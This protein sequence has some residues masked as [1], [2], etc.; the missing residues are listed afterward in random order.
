MTLI[1][2]SLKVPE[3]RAND[4]NDDGT[5]LKID[6]MLVFA[7]LEIKSEEKKKKSMYL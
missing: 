3:F 5:K 6:R 2:S 4:K 7:K 1:I